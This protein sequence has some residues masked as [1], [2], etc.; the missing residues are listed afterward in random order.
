MHNLYGLYHFLQF[1]RGGDKHRKKNGV[2]E[3]GDEESQLQ[4]GLKTNMVARRKTLQEKLSSKVSTVDKYARVLFP[5]VFLIL[6]AI[7]WSTYAIK[8]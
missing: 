3:I 4:D 7:Y 8:Y 1:H 2:L 5:L 6:N